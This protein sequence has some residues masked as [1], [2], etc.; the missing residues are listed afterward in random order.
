[1]LFAALNTLAGLIFSSFLRPILMV[2]SFPIL[3]FTLGLF[4]LVINAVLLMLVSWLLGDKFQVNGFWA[5]FFGALVISI[6]SLLLNSMT[7]SGNSRIQVTRGKVPP[8]RRDDDGG[9]PVIDV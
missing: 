2:L 5:A 8:N 4:M 7:G 9:G 1:M 3:I 6:V